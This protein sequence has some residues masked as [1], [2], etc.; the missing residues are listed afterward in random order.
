[1]ITSA[2]R[3]EPCQWRNLLTYIFLFGL[4][5]LPAAQPTPAQLIHDLRLLP[6]S[7]DGV[8]AGAAPTLFM[9]TPQAV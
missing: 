5:A 2:D 6:D 3:P 7:R 4:M 9:N 8:F 1:M